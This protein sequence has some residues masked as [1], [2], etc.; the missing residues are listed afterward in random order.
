M[1]RIGSLYAA[2]VVTPKGLARWVMIVS[3]F[4]F[5]LCYVATWAI[6]GKVLASEIQPAITRGVSNSVVQG[7]NSLINAFVALITPILID[8]SAYGAWFL[9]AGLSLFTTIVLGLY[10]P[11]PKDQPLETIQTG[12]SKPLQVHGARLWGVESSDGGSMW[13]SSSMFRLMDSIVIRA[14]GTSH[15]QYHFAVSSDRRHC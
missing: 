14:I 7:L 3:I 5:A 11:D 8:H 9:F 15:W 10:V 4:A 2:E 12:F 13:E 6:V 1:L